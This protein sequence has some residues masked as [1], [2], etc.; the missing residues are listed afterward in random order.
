MYNIFQSVQD[1]SLTLFEFIHRKLGDDSKCEEVAELV[2]CL[3]YL[4]SKKME[5][6]EKWVNTGERTVLILPKTLCHIL[7]N[8]GMKTIFFIC[9][10]NLFQR[11]SI[12][13]NCIYGFV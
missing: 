8:P 4:H 10:Q 11:I 7:N 13:N 12:F 1:P 9:V 2:D 3:E 6:N 5:I